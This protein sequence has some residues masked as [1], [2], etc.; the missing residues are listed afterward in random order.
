MY[1]QAQKENMAHS[2][3][4]TP[5]SL[6]PYMPLSNIGPHEIY[7][8]N[9]PYQVTYQPIT[10]PIYNSY[11]YPIESRDMYLPKTLPMEDYPVSYATQQP[12]IKNFQQHVSESF[13]IWNKAA[14]R[15]VKSVPKFDS[16]LDIDRLE[17]LCYDDVDN[18]RTSSAEQSLTK[19]NLI[20]KPEKM[21]PSPLPLSSPA[22]EPD[23]KTGT[24]KSRNNL[25]TPSNQTLVRP[26][27]TI[28]TVATGGTRPKET[29]KANGFASKETPKQIRVCSLLFFKKLLFFLHIRLFCRRMSGNVFSALTSTRRI[30][31]F[32]T[33][34]PSLGREVLKVNRFFVA[35][36]SVP[37][38]RWLTHLRKISALLA[39]LP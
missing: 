24:E 13:E 33:C 25:S 36:V 11:P 29:F 15:E 32:V 21:L 26:Q 22:R 5:A 14:N 4:N 7:P 38:A 18:S 31:K 37:T 35:V 6:N 12:D 1:Q 23:R 8:R 16:L 27:T 19:D 30:V 39:P 28:A 9:F 2:N 34:A 10:K 20:T 17:Q 3:Y